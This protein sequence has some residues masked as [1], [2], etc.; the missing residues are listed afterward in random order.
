VKNNI[1]QFLAKRARAWGSYDRD[2]R[3]VVVSNEVRNGDRELLDLLAVEAL[4]HRGKVFVID[5]DRVPGAESP[6]AAI[7]RY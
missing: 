4:S 6:A 5:P 2:Q 7:F 3:K 1:G